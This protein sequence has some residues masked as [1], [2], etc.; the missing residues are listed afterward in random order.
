MTDNPTLSLIEKRLGEI[1]TKL[2]ETSVSAAQ[3]EAK[4]V[5]DSV[6]SDLQAKIEE[7]TNQLN[8]FRAEMTK[9]KAFDL[10]GVRVAKALS[11]EAEAFDLGRFLKIMCR[12][13]DSERKEYGYEHEVLRQVNTPEAYEALLPNVKAA[14]GKVHTKAM[15]SGKTDSSGHFLIPLQV[16]AGIIPVLESMAVARS[17]GINVLPG[18]TSDLRWNSEEGTLTAMYVDTEAE[19]E[20]T[21]TST[22]F[23]K[24]DLKPHV[25]VIAGDL[26]WSM[27]NQPAIALDAWFRQRFAKK[28]ALFE[29]QKFFLGLGASKEPIGL[30]NVDGMT[31]ATTWAGVTY[32]GASQTVSKTLRKMVGAIED[33]NAIGNTPANSV[34]WFGPPRA[35]RKIQDTLD[36]DGKTIFLLDQQGNMPSLLTYKMGKTTQLEGTITNDRFGVGDFSTVFLG[37]WGTIAFAV[38]DQAGSNFTKLLTTLRAVV[39]HDV[40]FS[41]PKAFNLASNFDSTP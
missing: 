41:Q 10:S 36:G 29:D 22:S 37:E 34:A 8:G 16:Q 2:H 7:L 13:P 21:K 28:L 33:S 32:S 9:A 24:L 15:A 3:A 27:Q 38:S 18:L 12:H 4:S 26:T 35:F 39:A 14:L 25:A 30:F 11:G 5:A 6:R 19:E 20:V 31:A 40:G 1:E 17:L 23:G